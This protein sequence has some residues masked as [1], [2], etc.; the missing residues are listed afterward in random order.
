[1]KK[2]ISCHKY[3]FIILLLWSVVFSLLCVIGLGVEIFGL[4]EEKGAGLLAFG[5]FLCLSLFFLWSLNRLA[6]VV[7]IENGTVKRKGLIYGFYKQIAVSNIKSVV[8]KHTWRE[9]DFIY[10]VDD[11]TYKFNRARKDSYVC[12]AKTKKNLELLRSFWSGEIKE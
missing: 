6:C 10:L 7:W 12:F 11:S 8:V 4:A 1:M 2:T 9:G 5:I 3:G